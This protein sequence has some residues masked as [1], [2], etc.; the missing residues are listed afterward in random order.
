MGAYV[1]SKHAC[2]LALLFCGAQIAHAESAAAGRPEQPTRVPR[3]AAAWTAQITPYLWAT[4]L[5]GKVSP[6]QKA[7]T[8]GVEKSFSDVLGDLNGGGF[9]NVW[10]RRDRF[11]LSADVMYVSTTDAHGEG[12]LPAFQLPGIGIA[13]PPGASVDAKVDSKQFTAA[14][15]GGYRV[16]DTPAF[17][18]DVLAGARI[19]HISNDVTVTASHPAIKSLTAKHGESFHWVDP[20][21]AVRAFL[22]IT[23]RL[24][25][26]VQADVGGFGAGSNHTWSSLAAVNYVFSDRLSA[27]VGYKTLNVD[28]DRGGHVYDVRMRGPVLGLTYRF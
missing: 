8:L 11:V 4:G 20:L 24:S 5:S 7:P 15:Q 10:A 17:T 18:L 21:A 1:L 22:P 3:D 2:A 26:H 9:V 23:Q 14:L 16:V 27:S 19:W 6:F 28:Y 25:L 12:P 13:I